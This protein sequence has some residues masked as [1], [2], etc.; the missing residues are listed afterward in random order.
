MKTVIQLLV[1][2]AT[3]V[4]MITWALSANS[5][6]E[7]NTIASAIYGL[8]F[9][10][11]VIALILLFRWDKKR[12]NKEEIELRQR[13]EEQIKEALRYKQPVEFH[14]KQSQI[15]F[16][17]FMLVL[18]LGAIYFCIQQIRTFPAAQWQIGSILVSGS[19]LLCI[20][21]FCMAIVFT[22]KRLIGGP[23]IRLDIHGIHHF[24]FGFIPWTDIT[25][26][27]LIFLKVRSSEIS[28]LKVAT[29][30]NQHYLTRLNWWHRFFQGGKANIELSLQLSLSE[31]DSR[32]V[33][34]V[35]Q[36][37]AEYAGAPTIESQIGVVSP[38]PRNFSITC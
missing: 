18:G 2:L 25:N 31:K 36:G 15:I 4:G 34:G 7:G 8:F 12:I 14:I 16:L 27:H 19:V 37:Y 3:L 28:V 24:L 21:I 30:D 38:K 22:G 23:V 35:A 26:I 33:E 5:L 10:L 6:D 13:V 20:L 1:I 32:L 11:T 9:L 17:I 29:T